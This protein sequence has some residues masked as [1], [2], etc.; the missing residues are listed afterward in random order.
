[1]AANRT[2][3]TLPVNRGY[4]ISCLDGCMKDQK[5]I[6]LCLHGFTGSKRSIVIERLHQVMQAERIGTFCFDWPAHGESNASFS[7]LK[8]SSC[9]KDL[10]E[11]RTFLSDRFSVPIYCFATSFGG[12]ITTLYRQQN[13]ED[14]DKVILRSPALKMDEI[15]PSFLNRKQLKDFLR[16]TPLDFG[17]SQPLIL[18]KS[19]YEDICNHDAY[20]KEPPYPEK[21]LIIQGDADELVF[22]QW[23]VRYAERFGIKI[24]L[25]E[26]ADHVY[27]RPGAVETVMEIAKGFF[28]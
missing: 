4:S 22:P 11:V 17:M 15:I 20:T 12:Y 13:P 28:A 25:V 7:D 10:K 27:S 3:L 26:G 8:I 6:I 24:R 19:F 23:S 9:L 2:L 14:F 5:A 18:D 16:G 1:M 21:M